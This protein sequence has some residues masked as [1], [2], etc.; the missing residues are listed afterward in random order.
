MSGFIIETGNPAN[1]G[2]GL[3][4][5]GAARVSL[6]DRA[7]NAIVMPDF[8]TLTNAQMQGMPIT[9]I[10]W[11][12]SRNIRALSDGA[13]STGQTIIWSDPIDGAAVNSNKWS[14]V[15]V[16][17]TITQTS[18]VTLYNAVASAAITTGAAQISIQKFSIPQRG[19]LV[20]RRRY[21]LDAHQSGHVFESGFGAPVSATTAAVAG[22]GAFMRK[23]AA[24]SWRGVVLV[25][26]VEFVSTAAAI[27]DAAFVAAIGAAS[28]YF[29]VEV[30]LAND[31]VVFRILSYT[32]TVVLNDEVRAM[33]DGAST[34]SGWQSS[35]LSVFDREYNSTAL[36]AAVQLRAGAC[37]VSA[38]DQG[39]SVSPGM[40]AMLQ[41]NAGYQLPISSFGLTANYTKDTAPVL[42]TL[43]GTAAGETLLGGK[44]LVAAAV[45]AETDLIMFGFQNSTNYTL[46]I[47]RV[48]IGPPIVQ[49]AAVATAQT[50]IE[51][52]LGFNNTAVSLATAGTRYVALPGEHTAAIAAA[53]GAVFSG[54]N[55]EF[56][57]SS[58]GA[59][60]VYPGRFFH[61]IQR[62][63]SGA[64]TA[65]CA[66]RY[67]V[68]V[69]GRWI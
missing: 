69:I 15:A 60:P 9:G 58:D 8:T 67:N 34:F 52:A 55:I 50:T 51:Y 59:Y 1:P 47:E 16:T 40:L 20:W 38:I 23:D 27:A 42:R 4:D 44:I 22:D 57:A 5:V 33:G 28:K 12:A 43:V 19:R 61:I 65:S 31:E 3:I 25:G 14:N 54:G 13:L 32:G 7:G 63:T 39:L 18:G 35:K 11:R 24:G 2:E 21:S 53:V 68:L 26:G 10:D 56:A 41:G 37:S 49:G 36:G 45:G 46:L 17:H 6:N 30:E 62:Q 48:V 29:T 66:Y 64:A